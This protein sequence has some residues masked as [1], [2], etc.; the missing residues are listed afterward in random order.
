M[1][2]EDRQSCSGMYSQKAWGGDVE[3]FIL[4]KFKKYHMGDGP[5]V[6]PLVS[7]VIFEWKDEDLIGRYPN[8]EAMVNLP[9]YS[10]S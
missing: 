7:L 4:T 6:D 8:D 2:D 10:F 1:D 5:D 3:P 9:W